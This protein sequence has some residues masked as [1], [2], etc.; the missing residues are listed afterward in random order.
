[1]ETVNFAEI[2][3]SLI[4]KGKLTE[5]E[6]AE[7]VMTRQSTINRIRRGETQ[8]PRYDTAVKL[9]ELHKALEA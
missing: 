2:V 1:M 6:I 9:L 7:K 8:Y 3:Q 4:S 5:V